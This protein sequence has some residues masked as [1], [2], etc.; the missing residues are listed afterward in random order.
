MERLTIQE[1][2]L[3]LNVSQRT[4]REAIRNGE[5]RAFRQAGPRGEQWVVEVPEDGW[6]DRHKR[7]Y[8]ELAEGLPKWWWTNEAR[9]GRVHYL[10]QLG[11]EEIEPLYLCGLNSENIWSAAGH[12]PEERCPRCV[13]AATS[14]GFSLDTP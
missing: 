8:L 13:E 1:A 10:Q 5:L 2:S 7:S 4:I 11:I 9:H 12:S 6:V 14:Q 3:R